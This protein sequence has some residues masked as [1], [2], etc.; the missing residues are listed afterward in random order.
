[1]DIVEE[2]GVKYYEKAKR[3]YS[4][5][6][7]ECPKCKKHIERRR[8]QGINQDQ[9]QECF[10]AHHKQTQIKHGD[11]Y[12]RLYRT[13]VNMNARCSNPKDKHFSRYMGR[14]IAVSPEWK[15]YIVFKSWAE[16]NGYK[17]NLTIERIN[18]NGNYEPNNCEWITQSENSKRAATGRIG[19][20][21]LSIDKNTFLDMQSSRA[22]G[23]S[24]KEVLSLFK[25]SGT[26][27]YNA[28]K[29][30]EN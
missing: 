14:G 21:T 17:E 2:L 12:T 3:G 16:S 9:C 24:L 8:H 22:N 23:V 1:M 13:W 11:R 26:A 20:K 5:A 18:V 27:Y 30:Y 7:F 6:I 4:T 28:R 19:N 10:R 25:V 15:D 29:R